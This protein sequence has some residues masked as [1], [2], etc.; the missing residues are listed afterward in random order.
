MMT[1]KSTRV[2]TMTARTTTNA[3]SSKDVLL[4]KR[5]KAIICLQILIRLAE[6]E[7]SNE[8]WI[9][10]LQLVHVMTL[11]ISDQLI[12]EQVLTLSLCYVAQLDATFNPAYDISARYLLANIVINVMK[13]C[14][15]TPLISFICHM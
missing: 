15:R 13:Q 8:T 9:N 12:I 3:R 2:T 7:R 4:E 1:T 5:H 6:Q 11:F 14:S 10:H